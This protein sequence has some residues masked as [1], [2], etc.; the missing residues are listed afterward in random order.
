MTV[1]RGLKE[2]RED[3]KNLREFSIESYTLI[4]ISLLFLFLFLPYDNALVLS[5]LIMFPC[6]PCFFSCDTDI[7]I[8]LRKYLMSFN[9]VSY[10]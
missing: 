3:S 5:R 6:G 1:G 7:R 2:R 10:S 4:F 8:C 9:D